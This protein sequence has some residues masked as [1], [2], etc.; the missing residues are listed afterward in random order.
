MFEEISKMTVKRR[1]ALVRSC[2]KTMMGSGQNVLYWELRK[3]FASTPIEAQ[4]SVLKAFQF[5]IL[6]RYGWNEKIVM[7]HGK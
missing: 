2:L 1:V 5:P 3:L 6:Q 4:C 7:A